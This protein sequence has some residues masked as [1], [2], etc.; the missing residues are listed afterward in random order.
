MK[1]QIGTLG[2]ALHACV[3]PPWFLRMARRTERASRRGQVACDQFE[4]GGLIALHVGVDV[5]RG[6]AV[7]PDAVQGMP[8]EIGF[9]D[10][11]SGPASKE[12]KG[13]GAPDDPPFILLLPGR[14][15]TLNGV[16]L[17]FC[18]RMRKDDRGA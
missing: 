14:E 13:G 4:D 17:R 9:E 6:V 15:S 5:L 7:G 1:S 10:A 8:S 16:H 12:Q 18:E 3:S 11:V 2:V